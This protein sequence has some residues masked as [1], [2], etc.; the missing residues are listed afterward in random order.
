MPWWFVLVFI[1]PVTFFRCWKLFTVVIALVKV[2]F[3]K[4][5]LLLYVARGLPYIRKMQLCE[6]HNCVTFTSHCHE[7]NDNAVAFARGDVEKY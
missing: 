5:R 7:Q 1:K 6:V 4:N 3:T 2:Y